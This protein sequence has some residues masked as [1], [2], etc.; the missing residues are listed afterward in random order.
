VAYAVNSTT[1]RNFAIFTFTNY[2][3]MKNQFFKLLAAVLLTATLTT[4][5]F[6]QKTAV[7][8]V[9]SV[10]KANSWYAQHKIL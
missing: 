1:Y 6:A 10:T 5:A 4:N 3:F 9:W 2:Y 7:G 8:K